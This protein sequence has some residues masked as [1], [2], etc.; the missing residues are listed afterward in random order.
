V[1]SAQAARCAAD[2]EAY[3]PMH[4]LLFARQERWADS[5][6]PQALFADYV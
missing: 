3:W 6:A 2:Q 1:P 5:S 4:E